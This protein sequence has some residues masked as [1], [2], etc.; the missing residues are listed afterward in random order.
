MTSLSAPA[1]AS[2]ASHHGDWTCQCGLCVRWSERQKRVRSVGGW[3]TYIGRSIKCV[4][5]EPIPRKLNEHYDAQKMAYDLNPY[6]DMAVPERYPVDM[7]KFDEWKSRTEEGKARERKGC[8]VRI[9]G[10]PLVE[11]DRHEKLRTYLI[12]F[13]KKYSP[14]WDSSPCVATDLPREQACGSQ[15]V[16]VGGIRR[17][18]GRT[19]GYMLCEFRFR[20]DAHNFRMDIRM[21]KFDKKHTLE[22]KVIG[23][24]P[25]SPDHKV[26]HEEAPVPI[27]APTTSVCR[28]CSKKLC[29]HRLTT[30]WCNKCAKKNRQEPFSELPLDV[31]ELI[32]YHFE[33]THLCSLIMC[34]KE[35]KV[36]FDD[37]SIWEMIYHRHFLDRY[38]QKMLKRFVTSTDKPLETWSWPKDDIIDNKSNRVPLVIENTSDIPYVLL[39]GTNRMATGATGV[40]ATGDWY[41]QKGRYKIVRFKPMTTIQ[42]GG[43]YVCGNNAANSKWVLSPSRTWLKDNPVSNLSFSFQL[44]LLNL[45]DYN[46]SK[47]TKPAFLKTIRNSTAPTQ[48]IR[49]Y[50]L[51]PING[52]AD[53]K[54]ALYK[55]IHEEDPEKFKRLL[56]DGMK[57]ETIMDEE[58]KTLKARMKVLEKQRGKRKTHNASL[59]YMRSCQ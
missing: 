7:D 58:M 43:R 28:S 10:V 54:R 48:P 14:T 32:V 38:Y 37:Q 20:E 56:D 22:C 34:S 13:F 47:T 31:I 24:Y 9:T 57:E 27:I 19:L 17:I 8:I 45:T 21:R 2:A 53:Y 15:L 44:D 12:R 11:S 6:G 42:P 30:E 59:A 52:V 3:Q 39:W 4:S 26:H 33:Y 18:P 25:K 29:D 36:A 51:K 23:N 46:F 40:M 50:T 16:V 55:L 5:G 49:G 35:M 1:S 41:N